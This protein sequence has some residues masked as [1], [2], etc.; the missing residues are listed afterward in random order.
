MQSRTL[1]RSFT[2]SLQRV[3]EEMTKET[4]W[5]VTADLV[6]KISQENPHVAIYAA[7]VGDVTIL[8]WARIDGS[9]LVKH[10]CW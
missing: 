8:C 3:A 7:Q 10:V 4:H 1:P 5:D 6:T 2:V 9:F